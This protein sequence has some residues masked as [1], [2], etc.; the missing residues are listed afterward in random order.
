M[1]KDKSSKD[2]KSGK[3]WQETKQWGDTASTWSGFGK[4]VAGKRGE[5]WGRKADDSIRKSAEDRAK[6]DGWW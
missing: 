4:K 6:R 5:Q 2:S 3:S 1:A